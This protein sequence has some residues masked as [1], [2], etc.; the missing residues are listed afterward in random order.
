MRLRKE[1]P[2]RVFCLF[3]NNLFLNISVSQALLA[4]NIYYIDIT[5]KNAVGFPK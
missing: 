2:T 1:H 4:L 5:R 3:F